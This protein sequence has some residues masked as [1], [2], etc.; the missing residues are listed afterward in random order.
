MKELRT[1][2]ITTNMEKFKNPD[3]VSFK[4]VDSPI[5]LESDSSNR[6]LI[7]LAHPGQF[8]DVMLELGRKDFPMKL[9]W[10]ESFLSG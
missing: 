2:P 8:S 7:S 4:E 6:V 10:F 5:Y 9:N 3:N 1:Y